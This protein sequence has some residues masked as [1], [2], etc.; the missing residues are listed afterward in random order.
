[1]NIKRRLPAEWEAQDAVQLTLPHADTDWADDMENVKAC[2]QKIAYEISSRQKLIAVCTDLDEAKEWLKECPQENIIY[3]HIPSNDSWARDHGA[4]TIQE[5]GELKL[6]DFT[7]NG[8]GLKFASDK[9]NQISQQLL[10]NGVFNVPM[11]TTGFVLEGGGIE[12][13]GEDTLMTTAHCIYSYNRNAGKTEEEILSM[14]KEYFGSEQILVLENGYLAGD[15][16]DSHID[17]LAR[18]CPNNTIAYV[19][20][21]DETDE[22]FEALQKM[23]AELKTFK[24]LNGEAY[25]LVALPMAPKRFKPEEGYRLPSTYANFL[26]INGA[27]LLPVY[28]DEELDQ[29]AITALEDCFPEHEIVAIN[30]EA[31]IRQHGSLHCVS[32]QYFKGVVK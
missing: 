5:N 21:T 23:E 30:C 3:Q 2:F 29:K 22:H 15:D 24:N 18:F 32:M 4:I 11:H 25:R 17:T 10:D 26:I 9:D 6:L 12:S 8:W 1:M 20:C 27:V 16:T 7:F 13:D 28:G 19:Q 14:M 31:L